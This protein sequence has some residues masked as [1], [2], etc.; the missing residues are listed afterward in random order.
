MKSTMGSAADEV[1]S[2]KGM[3]E[4]LVAVTGARQAPP[5]ARANPGALPGLYEDNEPM[6]NNRISVALHLRAITTLGISHNRRDMVD[7]TRAYR[8]EGY[9]SHHFCTWWDAVG[10]VKAVQQWKIKLSSLGAVEHQVAALK[11]LAEI[12]DFVYQ[13]LG[14][15]GTI[16]AAILQ[17]GPLA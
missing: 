11:N 10:K 15:D 4:N 1:K 2:V 8:L 3:L 16:S 9:E 6:L 5:G 17:S 13:H 7:Y 12:G 14:N